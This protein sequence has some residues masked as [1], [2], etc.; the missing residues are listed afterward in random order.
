MSIVVAG[1]QM[2]PVMMDRAANLDAM[3]RELRR[4]AAAGAGL[5]I[6]PEAAVTGYCFRSKA[7]AVPIAEEIPGES[8]ERLGAVCRELGVHAVYGTLE[9]SDDHI[10]NAAVLV[11]PNGLI[12]S[13]RKTHMPY[14]GIDRFATP[15]DRKYE[16]FEAA[17]LR[18]G[19]L[20][21]Y[22]GSFP[23]SARCLTLMGADLICLPTNWPTGGASAADYLTNARALENT[24]YFAAVNRVGK[25]RG[26]QFIGKSRICA[27][28][29]ESLAEAWH[30]QPAMILAEVDPKLARQKHLVRIPHEH[31]IDRFKDRRPD[32]YGPLVEPV[33]AD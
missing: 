3:E 4:A 21:C 5:V 19:M 9:R 13:Y 30:D 14:L 22:D 32:L 29:G 6:F 20:I 15:G 25:E 18:I 16:V 27:P 11:G 31:E 26:F 8:V 28:T 17:G 24:I 7:E 33:S 2:E 12:G 23:E 10:Y 1:I